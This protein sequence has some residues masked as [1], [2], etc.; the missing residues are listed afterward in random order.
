MPTA[1][2]CTRSPLIRATTAMRPCSP[3][4]A[5]CGPAGTTRPARMPCRCTR[6]TRTAPT[7]SSTTAPTATTP[8]P[9]TPSSSSCIRGRCRTDASSRIARQYTDVDDGGDLVIIDGTHYVENTQALL[10]NPASPA[11]RRLPATQNN[12]LTIPGPSP[13]GPLHLRLSAAGRHRAHP[14][15]LDPVPAAGY[16]ADPA[17]DRAVHLRQPERGEPDGGA[18]AVQ[19]VDVRSERRTPCSRS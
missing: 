10:G 4:A 19:R 3:T 17:D 5:C 16:D 18:A 15:Q 14:G 2:A 11:R 9:T 8:A 7:W 13:G 12:V 6:P 1:R